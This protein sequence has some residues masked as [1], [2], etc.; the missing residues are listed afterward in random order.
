MTLSKKNRH[1]TTNQ[2]GLTD[3]QE[4]FLVRIL[5]A[6]EDNSYDTPD[7]KELAQELGVPVQSVAG[8]LKLAEKKGLIVAVSEDVLYTPKQLEAMRST[9]RDTFGETHFSLSQARDLFK[10]TRRYMAP[11]L[12]YFDAESITVRTEEG[13][14]ISAEPLPRGVPMTRTQET[15]S[16][17]ESEG[18]K[19]P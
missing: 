6:L 5:Q 13:R 19:I 2:N 11:L 10:T 15:S 1:S 7:P 14:T 18:F 9:L 3:K 12:D 4:L 17:P 8:M 16:P